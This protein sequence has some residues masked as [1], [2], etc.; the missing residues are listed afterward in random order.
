MDAILLLGH[1]SRLTEANKT[2]RHMAC[3]VK[4]I[5]DLPFVEIAFLQFQKPDFFEAVSTCISKGAKKIIIHPYLLYKGRHLEEDITEM[6]IEAQKRYNDIEF[7]LTEPL[8][9]H[10][11]IAKVVLERSKKNIKA[12]KILKPHEIEEKSLEIITEELRQSQ[13]GKTNFRDIELPVVKRVIHATGDFDFTRNMRF[14]PEAVEAGIRAIKNGMDILVDVQMVEVGINKKLLQKW[15]GKVICKIQNKEQET[16]NKENMTKAEI[17]IEMAVKGNNN[18]GIVAIGNAP[19]ALYKTMKL[20]RNEGFKPELVIGVPVGFVKAVESKEVLLH[21][22]YP[23]ITL[24][25]RKGGSPI[26]VA[27]VNALLKMAEGGG[28]KRESKN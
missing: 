22:K 18:I 3:M 21:M 20:I 23:F 2:L 25:G 7:V 26:A 15:G 1:G 11:N 5:G 9:V 13:P 28:D 19:T 24:L 12:I 4:E 6:I 8:G 17:G 16:K 14:H 27:I 10:E